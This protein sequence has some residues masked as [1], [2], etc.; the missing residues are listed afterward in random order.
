MAVS[1]ILDYRTGGARVRRRTSEVVVV[2]V[3]EEKIAK[4]GRR[5]VECSRS[6]VRR[7]GAPQGSHGQRASCLLLNRIH[8][9]GG[10]SSEV[11]W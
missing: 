2:V 6:D 10:G 7:D 5:S 8:D 4:R 11:R 9:C 1:V 3:D